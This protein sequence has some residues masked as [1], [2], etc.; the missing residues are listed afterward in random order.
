MKLVE[1]VPNF[2]EGRDRGVIDAI[3]AAIAAG[4][5][6]H[7]L[8]VDPGRDTNRTVVTFVAPLERAADA[9]F[10]GIAKAAELIDMAA[11]RGAHPRMGATDVCPFVP[12]GTTTMAECVQLARTLGARVGKE[13]GIPV[14]LYEF[15]AASEERRNLA[16]IRTGEYEGLADKLK[17]P[18]WKPDFGMATFN[19]RSGA[20]V[21]GARKFLIAYNVNLNTRDKRKANDIAFSIRE[22]GRKK[23]DEHGRFVRDMSGDFV[24]EPGTLRE[25][26]AVGWYID[27]YQRAQIS[28]NLTDFDVTP[29]HL[30]F[31]E[32]AR[33][34]ESRG[35]RATGSELVG[36]I[37]L[38]ALRRAG[39][40]YLAK[41]G[42]SCGVPESELIETAI[43]SLGL[44]ELGGFDPQ[45]K[46]IEYRVAAPSPL[47]SATV[48]GFADLTSTEAP[49]PG[50][51]S[52][53]ALCGA[54]ASALTSM[55]AN[56]TFGKKDYQDVWEEMSTLAA[57]AQALKDTFLRAV[58]D[59]ARAFDAVMGANRLPK[60]SPDEEARRD[61]AIQIAT[62]RAIDVPL[63]V[64]RAC[65]CA[66]PLVERVAETG[67]TN[68]ISDA[69][70]AS[71][72]LRTAVEGAWLNVLI[73]LPGITDTAYANATRAEGK[74][75]L[76]T[77]V[78]RCQRVGAQVEAG[79][80]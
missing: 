14:Y 19:A 39:L 23:R 49:V 53:A 24:F 22:S 25:C 6:V 35:L 15:A 64:M 68:S 67:N 74:K 2:S 57:Q 3:V 20:T 75:L 32:V 38:E 62:H 41:Q 10:R 45:Q 40:H 55:V 71:S 16:T 13:L 78:K 54:L 60:S 61:A 56:L 73:N 17:D 30:A 70:V 58:D 59:D 33:Q 5:G 66:V 79:L 26:K 72:A 76:E 7:V 9:A 80:H 47:V 77:V 50:G 29:P 44:R 8:D 46:I 65:E 11:H 63:S 1:C 18:D 34:A 43:Q 37:P 27:E 12:L 36:L 21:I 4:E 28:I 51:G 48:R 52:V 31:D 69:G 42:S